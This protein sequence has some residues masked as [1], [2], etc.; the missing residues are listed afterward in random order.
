MRNDVKDED[1]EL[2]ECRVELLPGQNVITAIALSRDRAESSPEHFT[3]AYKGPPKET[4]LHVVAIGIN[5]YKNPDYRLNYG[6]PDAKAILGFFDNGQHRLYKSIEARQLL[7]KKAT[8]RAIVKRL[9]K[10]AKAE[11]QDTVVLYMAGHGDTLDGE[12]YFWPYDLVRPEGERERRKKGLSRT[13]LLDL[14][15]GVGAQ[16]VLML[17]DSCKSGA[18]LTTRGVAADRKA[19]SQLARAAGV[20]LVAAAGQQQFATELAELGHGVFTYAVLEGLAGGADTAPGDGNV[21]I[22]ELLGYIDRRIPEVSRQYKAKPQYP[23]VDSRGRNFP[24][25]I[26]H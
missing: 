1:L 8:K 26:V 2:R 20:H 19:L 3:V 18:A 10:L 23:V 13:E 24:L 22:Y 5:E 12:W 6:V 15:A 9:K 7:D 25:A 21:R 11:P 4:T 16:K 17:I 14:V